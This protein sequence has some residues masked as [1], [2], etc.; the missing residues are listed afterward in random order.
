MPALQVWKVGGV[1]NL[2]R[3]YRFKKKA[4]GGG[5]FAEKRKFKIS[6]E[7]IGWWIDEISNRGRKIG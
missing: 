6:L 1:L 2:F 3:G 5:W 7:N 4:D